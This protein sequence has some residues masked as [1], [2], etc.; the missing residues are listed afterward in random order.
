MCAYGRAVQH[1]EPVA[2][3]EIRPGLTPWDRSRLALLVVWALLLLLVLTLGQRE[4]PLADLESAVA[5]GRV[6]SVLVLGQS[7][8]GD[9]FS[10]QEVRWTD[11]LV[12]RT[13]RATVGAAPFEGVVDGPVR[14]EDLGV[15]LS[16]ADPDLEVRRSPDGMGAPY[17]ELLGWRVPGWLAL[18][19][20]VAFLVQLGLLVHGPQPWRATRWAWFWILTVPVVG[21]VLMLL[22]SGRTPGLPAPTAAG[23]RL[24]GGWAFL[25][26]STVTTLLSNG[27]P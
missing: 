24:T 18:T 9:G 17:G 1:T 6:D 5:A 19:A 8:T 27:G 26:S 22:L 3:L 12:R 11:G 2:A 4:T 21:V 10:T 25:L 20:L 16:R 15:L 13:S 7:G 14:T 23:R